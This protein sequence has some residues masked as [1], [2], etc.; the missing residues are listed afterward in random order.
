M[1]WPA[2]FRVVSL[3][4]AVVIL[5]AVPGVVAQL[6]PTI[7]AGGWAGQVEFGRV[8]ETDQGVVEYV[9]GG[10]LDVTAS[11]DG[12]DN[13]NVRGDFVFDVRVTANAPLGS[14]DRWYRGT[15]RAEGYGTRLDSSGP[16]SVNGLDGARVD[17]SV[18]MKYVP[19]GV[20][21]EGRGGFNVAAASCLS[22]SGEFVTEII[23]LPGALA[24]PAFVAPFVLFPADSS[25]LEDD[26]QEIEQ[27]ASM[28][29]QWLAS[30]TTNNWNTRDAILAEVRVLLG[31]VRD[32]NQ[33]IADLGLCG[34]VSGDYL[35]GGVAHQWIADMLGNFAYLIG[36]ANT[37][38]PGTVSAEFMID[39]YGL[40]SSAG[41]FD[42]LSSDAIQTMN[43][44]PIE[45]EKLLAVAQAD[46][47]QDTVDAIYAAALQ[48][49]WDFLADQAKPA[50]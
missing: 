16:V 22:V 7:P 21:T 34:P 48:W 2:R 9:G 13:V 44:Y 19:I 50:P 4:A 36:F 24:G 28:I 15:W 18:T 30:P 38:V 32:L 23:A 17:S 39:A 33:S 31:L 10:R 12:E 1:V 8:D 29:W 47:K 37:K 26:V 5:T 11:T 46:G 43:V 14:S 42:S 45:L 3:I 41:A 49:G 40:A 35:P 27:K 25:E 20:E 6:E